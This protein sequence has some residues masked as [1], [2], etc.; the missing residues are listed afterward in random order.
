MWFGLPDVLLWYLTSFRWAYWVSQF[1]ETAV[2]VQVFILNFLQVVSE[3]KQF[4]SYRLVPDFTL[5]SYLELHSFFFWYFSFL[6]GFLIH[7]CV[8]H[9]SDRTERLACTPLLRGT[10]FKPTWQAVKRTAVIC[11]VIKVSLSA[12]TSSVNTSIFDC[13][14][15]SQRVV[16]WPEIFFVFL[17]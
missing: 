4:I 10:F 15:F 2:L 1:T 9:S 7:V 8:L 12:R 16:C 14:R 13:Q 6:K 17:C 5:Y 11:V 3:S